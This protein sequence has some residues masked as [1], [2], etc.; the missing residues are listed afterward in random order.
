MG[1]LV[2][3]PYF[4]SESAYADQQLDAAN[5]RRAK[6]DRVLGVDDES[7]P[8]KLCQMNIS[9]RM[10]KQFDGRVI[11]RTITSR[12]RDGKP[13]IDLPPLTIIYGIIK[14]TD[15]EMAIINMQTEATIDA[16]VIF[17]IF[18]N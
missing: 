5:L 8:Y 14:L 6:Q 7:D 4:F 15:R 12:D 17:C 13:L 16:Y 2:G 9:L 10:Q 18:L 1:R 11:R 3:I